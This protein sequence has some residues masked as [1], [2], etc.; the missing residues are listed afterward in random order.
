MRG[1]RKSGINAGSRKT[2]SFQHRPY[3]C[4]HRSP[5]PVASQG[6]TC[7]LLKQVEESRVGQSSMFRER[8]E[9]LRFARQ[10]MNRLNRV[11]DPLV[12]CTMGVDS[13]QFFQ[14]WLYFPPG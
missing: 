14:L 10:F 1:T 5:E 4:I 13:Q 9:G 7:R 12:E 2:C 11:D 8:I 3:S 6:H